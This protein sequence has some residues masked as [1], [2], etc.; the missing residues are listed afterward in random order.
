MDSFDYALLETYWAVTAVVLN[1]DICIVR[2]AFWRSFDKVW[3]VAMEQYLNV[4]LET[5]LRETCSTVW[6]LYRSTR[7]YLNGGKRIIYHFTKCMLLLHKKK[8]SFTAV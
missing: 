5:A 4:S 6:N 3:K 7:I 2:A 8:H 1:C